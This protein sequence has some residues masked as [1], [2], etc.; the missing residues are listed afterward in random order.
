[1]HRK[2]EITPSTTAKIAQL[3]EHDLA[4]VGVAGSSPVCRSFNPCICKDF[5]LCSLLIHVVFDNNTHFY[6]RTIYNSVENYEDKDAD[7][8]DLKNIFLLK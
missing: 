2:S 7:F 6:I 8:E 4:K 1:M 3:V 5:L